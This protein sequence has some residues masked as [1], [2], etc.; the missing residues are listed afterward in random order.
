MMSPGS[1]KEAQNLQKVGK[2]EAQKLSD[3]RERFLMVFWS[4][5][6]RNMSDFLSKKV[7]RILMEKKNTEF[8]KIVLLPQREHQNEGPEGT[9]IN[10][11]S[12]EILL[13]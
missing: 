6:G 1:P 2:N 7:C 11:K 12:R 9:R 4:I 3:S 8:V 13:F 5:C 10:R